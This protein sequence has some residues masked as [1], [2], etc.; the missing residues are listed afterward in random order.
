M[1]IPNERY[2]VLSSNGYKQPVCAFGSPDG[3]RWHLI[4]KEPVINVYH[5]AAAAYDSH[6]CTRW[7]PATK[8]YV[9]Y[10]R[11]WYRPVEPKVRNVAIRTSEDFIHWTPLRRRDFGNT[12]PEHLYTNAI[13]P[14][15]TAM[16]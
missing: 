1:G 8:L 3:I 12:P 7:D 5:G 15:S 9:V 6:F 4:Q 10:H 16:R 14:R 13:A 2:K 11:I